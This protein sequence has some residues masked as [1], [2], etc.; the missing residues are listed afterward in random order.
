MFTFEMILVNVNKKLV[1]H[2]NLTKLKKLYKHLILKY[3]TK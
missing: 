2:V 1:L 3:G